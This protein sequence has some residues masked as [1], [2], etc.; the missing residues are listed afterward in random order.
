MNEFLTSLGVLILA[1][2]SPVL[3][4]FEYFQKSPVA[5][6]LPAEQAINKYQFRRAIVIGIPSCV[7]GIIAAVGLISPICN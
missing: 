3:V 6:D 4:I 7:G 2:T 1:L 5:M